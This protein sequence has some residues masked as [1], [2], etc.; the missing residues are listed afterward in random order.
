MSA[1]SSAVDIDIWTVNKLIDAVSSN[2]N[3][4]TRVTIPEYQRRLVWNKSTRKE[5]IQS[6]KRGYPFGS[7]LL[8]DDI[9]RGQKAGDGKRYYNLIDGLQRTQALKSYI[10]NQNGYFTRADLDDDF[11]DT[12]ARHLGKE[13]D[14]HRDKI[15]Q[16]VV[17][18]VKRKPSFEAR[19]G[20][21]TDNLIEAL[22]KNVLKYDPDSFLFKEVY[23]DL[24]RSR[25]LSSQLGGFLDRVSQ[26][27]KTIPDAKIPVLIYTGPASELPRVFEL[28]NSKGTALSRYEIFAAQWINFRRKIQNH[29]IVDAIW[30]KYEALEDEGFTLDVAEETADQ[31]SR[32]AREYTLFDYLFG[33]GQFLS[34]KFP[35]L[36]KTV[37]V[38]QP[39]SVGFNL[40][41]ACVGLH[42]KDM[43]NLPDKIKSMNIATLEQG[44]LQSVR[45]VDNL[46]KPML[47]VKQ[48]GR[49]KAPIYHSDLMI[50]SMIATVFQARYGLRDLKEN[51]SWRTDRRK[52]KKHLPM[53]YLHDILHDDWRGSGDSKLYA[54][55]NDLHYLNNEPPTAQRWKQVLDD[56]HIA[57]QAT[58]VHTK[59]TKRHIRDSRPEYLLLKYIF[60][61]RMKNAKT[62]HVEHIIPVTQL[63]S[64]MN[65]G[66][67][68]PI[69]TIGN[70]A[71]LE[72]AG[73][74]KKNEQPYDTMLQDKLQRGE[75]TEAEYNDGLKTYE[76]LLLCPPRLLPE[77]LSKDNYENFLSHRF[78]Y[79]QDR[80]IEVWQS[81][82]PPAASK[83]LRPSR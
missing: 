47:A 57:N 46:L 39:S 71:L 4:N 2:P 13:T 5:L 69:N 82:I 80:F 51:S 54:A 35:R 24:N 70:L 73:D 83:A 16:T 23:F 61:D 29:A 52:L 58:H 55:V 32:R 12:I 6:I 25:G 74:L 65:E 27:I 45:F 66:D 21:R 11:V 26:E 30:K 50:I 53:F 43:G 63:Q 49:A 19:D 31:A 14:E 42:I 62:Y 37:K 56:W 59:D 44:I 22:M 15:R 41:T 72:K 75:I 68:W 60:V 28:L 78:K 18:W 36:F 20:W 34:E 77:S 33:L 48:Y 38:D 9:A 76:S 64:A 81:H 67:A 7:I 3:G 8:Y 10:E 17:E 1:F 40:T 79:L